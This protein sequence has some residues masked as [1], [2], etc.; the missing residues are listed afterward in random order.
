MTQ[1]GYLTYLPPIFSEIREF[2]ALGRV[3]DSF[4]GEAY[5][6]INGM[7]TGFFVNT[8]EGE[9]LHRHEKQYGVMPKSSETED[10]RRFRLMTMTA[11]E[12]PF[13]MRNLKRKLAVLCGEGNY[14]AT[15]DAS[16]CTLKVTVSLQS[17]EKA[18]LLYDML[19]RIT[20]A[21]LTL[22]IENK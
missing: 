4:I 19:R 12:L 9:W 14:T 10:E 22:T 5:E 1:K 16:K 7:I 2:R 15:A 3:I 20:P 18:A 8:A 11:G 21:N 17:E 6:D 13:T